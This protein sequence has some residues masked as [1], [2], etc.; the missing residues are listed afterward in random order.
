VHVNGNVQPGGAE[1][2]KNE[3]SHPSNG[4]ESKGSFLPGQPDAASDHAEAQKHHEGD[5]I[6]ENG[7]IVAD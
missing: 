4:Y 2:K 3:K 6:V 1:R 5:Q 7:E